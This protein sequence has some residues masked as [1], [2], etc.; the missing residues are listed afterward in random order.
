[1]IDYLGNEWNVD[2]IG[3][4]ISRGDIKIPGGIIYDGKYTILGPDPEIP[5]P[6]FLIINVKRHVNSFSELSKEERNE[7]SNVIFYAE[8]TLKKLKVK[9]ITLLQEERSKHF[10]IWIFPHYTWM[11][12]KFGRG[13]TYLRDISKYARENAT[14][15]TIKEVLEVIEKVR[16][17]IKQN[18]INE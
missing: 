17:Y 15:D 9:E 2:C 14:E 12:E 8:K 5:I 10:H 16:E 3:C 1:M 7:I 13:V 11:T 4:A 18:I 6:G